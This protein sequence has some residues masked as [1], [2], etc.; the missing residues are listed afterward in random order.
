MIPLQ[1]SQLQLFYGIDTEDFIS[2]GFQNFDLDLGFNQVILNLYPTLCEN[3]IDCQIKSP[4]PKTASYKGQPF[5]YQSANTFLSWENVSAGMVGSRDQF[6][7]LR[8]FAVANAN[9]DG[10]SPG[11]SPKRKD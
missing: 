5:T 9:F 11:E 6:N 4:E 8:T 7:L 10:Q 3:E 2:S 1:G